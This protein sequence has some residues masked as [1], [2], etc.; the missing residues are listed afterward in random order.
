MTQC[1]EHHPPEEQLTRN[2]RLVLDA[3]RSEDGPLTAYNLL[4]RL[5]DEGLRAPPQIYRALEKLVETGIVHRLESRNAFVSCNHAHCGGQGVLFAV[6]DDCGSIE[7]L[8]TDAI[9][10]ALRSTTEAIGFHA[11]RLAGEVRGV[12]RPC[13]L[14]KTAS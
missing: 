12:C 5:R 11:H 10:A 14:K 4:D 9:D 2:Q 13:G 3:L 8:R 1:C 6:C 7:E